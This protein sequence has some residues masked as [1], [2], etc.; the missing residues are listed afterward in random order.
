MADV[1]MT[2]NEDKTASI[3]R[4]F[5]GVQGEQLTITV[6]V[7]DS[8]KALGYDA[9]IDFLRPDGV[10]YY[11]G[12]Y[13]CSS[14]TF[15]CLLGATD[16]VLARNGTAMWQFVLATMVGTVRTVIWA[17]IAYKTEIL[18]SVCATTAAV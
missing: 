11:K 15:D 4:S 18:Y 12:A 14:G 7:A 16:S 10:A 9:Y 13:D 1:I 6:N 17:S 5:L 8:L 2:I 3:D